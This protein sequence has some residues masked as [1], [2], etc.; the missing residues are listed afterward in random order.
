MGMFDK[1]NYKRTVKEGIDTSEMFFIGLKEFCDKEVAVDGFYF[2]DKGNYGRKVVV[3]GEGYLINM[4]QRAVEQFERINDDARMV[5][6][7]L[8][9]HLKITNIRMLETRNGTTVAYD[10]SDC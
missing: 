8:E 1:L 9:G 4:P 5:K 2:N 7:V 6:A 3:V 10:L